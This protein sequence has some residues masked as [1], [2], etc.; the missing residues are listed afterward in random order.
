MIYVIINNIHIAEL[1]NAVKAMIS[2]QKQQTAAS[3]RVNLYIAVLQFE[4]AI[5]VTESSSV[6]EILMCLARKI[7]IRCLNIILK[8]CI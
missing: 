2:K 3:V 1:I 4:T 6:C 8:D 7:I 5:T